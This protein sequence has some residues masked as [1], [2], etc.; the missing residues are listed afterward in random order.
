MCLVLTHHTVTDYDK[1]KAV[2]DDDS[3]RRRLAG[4]VNA[5]VYRVTDSSNEVVSIFEWNDTARA[6]KWATSFETSEAVEWAG[7]VGGPKVYVLEEAG[8]APA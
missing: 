3:E 4:S 5:H 2:W 7:V 8:S 6:R 1:F